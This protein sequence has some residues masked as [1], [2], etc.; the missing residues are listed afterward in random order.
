VTQNSTQDV[1]QYE[2]RDRIATISLNRPEKLNAFNDDMV[3]QLMAAFH[4]FDMDDDAFVAVLRGNGRAFCSGADVRARQLRSREELSKGGGPSAQDAKSADIMSRSVNWKP[5][6]SAVH[7]YA[8]GLGTG[9]ALDCDMVVAQAGTKFQITE[10]PRGLAGSGKLMNLMA[11]RGMGSFAVDV[12]ITGRFFTAEEAKAAG[13]VDQV[14]PE[15]KLTET[16]YELA[17]SINKNPPLAVRACIQL[18]RWEIE[19]RRRQALRYATM[20]KL[21]LT[22]DFA[23]AAKAFVEKRA[24]APF[25]AR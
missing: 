13:V 21:Y 8:V 7:G 14:A 18:R 2:C 24:P 3:R 20:N 25:K 10:T 19:D 12:C 22:E 5:V 15:G 11:Y 23:E 1:I 16:A 6:I 17:N 4:R 9:L